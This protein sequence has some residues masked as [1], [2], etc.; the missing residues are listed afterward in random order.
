MDSDNG[1]SYFPFDGSDSAAV[2][3][4]PSETKRANGNAAGTGLSPRTLK[5]VEEIKAA[6]R[7]SLIDAM[8]RTRRVDPVRKNPKGLS[9]LDS[10]IRELERTVTRLLPQVQR[11]TGRVLKGEKCNA[12]AVAA[13]A[14]RLTG[15]GKLG[16][17]LRTRVPQRRRSQLSAA[18]KPA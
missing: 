3:R 4:F 2:N 1:N 11:I 5:K 12:L 13:L 14:K 18:P 6:G 7:E 10:Q 16:V 17:R 15:L 8:E 9:P